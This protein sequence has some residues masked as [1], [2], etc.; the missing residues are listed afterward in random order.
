MVIMAR[1]SDLI[2]Q[3]VTGMREK[4]LSAEG[5]VTDITDV[6]TTAALIARLRP[7]DVFVNMA[8]PAIIP[9]PIPSQMILMR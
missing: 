7:F 9:A 2:D 1:R 6:D 5:V 3:V 4:G 8:L